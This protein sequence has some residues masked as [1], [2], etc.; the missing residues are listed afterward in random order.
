MRNGQPLL[1]QDV[2]VAAVD[3][4]GGAPYQLPHT[5]DFFVCDLSSKVYCVVGKGYVS[6]SS[7]LVVY[8]T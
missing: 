4:A 5:T 3:G 6:P 8:S 7:D 1:V 2:R